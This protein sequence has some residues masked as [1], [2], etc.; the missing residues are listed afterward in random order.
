MLAMAVTA[1]LVPATLASSSALADTK[2]DL[3]TAKAR[4]AALER[5]IG[6]E[7]QA[8]G[9]LH[10]Q[11]TAL[12]IKLAG[13][14]SRYQT[15]LDELAAVNAGLRITQARYEELQSQLN[16]RAAATYMQG[17][18]SIL[19]I[20]LGATSLTDFTERIQFV[21]SLSR[22]D[23]DLGLEAELT[24]VLL[25]RQQDQLEATQARQ[26]A[27]LHELNA[28][29]DL[30]TR[31]LAEQQAALASLS[32]ARSQAAALVLQLKNRLVKEELA[33][34]QL[35]LHGGTPIP[36][37]QWAGFFLP[38]LGAPTCRNNLVLTVAWE[39]TEYTMATWNPLATSYPMPGATTFNSSGVKN[40]PTMDSGITA[41]VNTLESTNPAFNY[42]PIVRDLRACADPLVTADA[43]NHSAYC[44]CSGSYP[45][46]YLVPFVED[47][48][49]FYAKI[50]TG[51]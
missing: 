33:A 43:I 37:G 5:E 12:A 19:E 29:R 9:V 6:S 30:M 35:A 20:I 31:K 13:A 49:D 24:S 26:G 23:A 36:F 47:N 18:G 50:C 10:G 28:E 21:N 42:A 1:A 16:V 46:T 17:S 39:A 48:Y 45:L 25:G 11:L 2:S 3:A 40:Y 7:V 15:T 8:L 51:C 44:T 22:V 27:A 32:G 41:E 38:R 34:A 4:L 14:T